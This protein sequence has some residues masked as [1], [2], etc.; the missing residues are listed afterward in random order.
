[1]SEVQVEKV[2]VKTGEVLDLTVTPKDDMRSL[3]KDADKGVF[4]AMSKLATLNW[5][6]LKPNET[7]L[8][9]MQKPFTVSG[10]GVMYLNFKQA[11]LFAVRCYELELSP[12]SS[13]VWFDPNRS[14]VNLTLEGKRE[15]AR[16]KGIDLGPPKFE[17]QT[18]EWK[19]VRTTETTTECAKA[20]FPKDIG[21]KCSIRVGNPAHGE[22]V[23]YTAWLSEWFVSRSPV[24]KAKPEHMLQT[25]ATEKAI[26][27]CMGT[28][29][30]DMV[31]SEPDGK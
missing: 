13:G 24:W 11:L 2:D 31:G 21:Y 12:F 25:R 7:A 26:S 18:R 1:M 4:D 6:D 14:T 8:L 19:D 30:S 17:I 28:G 22:S 9:L 29:A 20:G 10:G 16:I 3:V 27:L 15:L 23:D 5:R